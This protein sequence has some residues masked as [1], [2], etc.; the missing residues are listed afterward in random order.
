MNNRIS[1]S[2]FDFHLFLSGGRPTVWVAGIWA[3]VDSGSEKGKYLP[4]VTQNFSIT[5]V[6]CHKD[7]KAPS[8]N[9]GAL[10]NITPIPG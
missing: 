4:N 3:G 10:S 9:G 1:E 2:G 8:R 6:L 7:H 5:M